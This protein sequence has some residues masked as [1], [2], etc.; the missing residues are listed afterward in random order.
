MGRTG[1]PGHLL[2]YELSELAVTDEMISTVRIKWEVSYFSNMGN[3]VNHSSGVVACDD[4]T[5]FNLDPTLPK[6]CRDNPANLFLQWNG[7]SVD[8][9][10]VGTGV[11]ISKFK[12]KI[13][14]D[15]ETITDKDETYTLG[16]SRRKSR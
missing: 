2:R 14:S 4:S 13:L 15:S 8:G 12:Y 16:I 3:F 9:R 7:R 10:L 11:Y 1:L 5:V 6:N